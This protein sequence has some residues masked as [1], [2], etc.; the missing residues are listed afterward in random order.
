M[1]ACWVAA[2]RSSRLK[3]GMTANV[4]AAIFGGM[5][6]V[7]PPLGAARAA[8]TAWVGDEHAA[9]RLVTAVEATGSGRR[10]DAGLEI[11]MAPGWHTYWRTP[12]DAGIPPE[13]DWTGSTNLAR[14]EIAW[15]APTRLS[16]HGLES[17]V[18]PDHALA[19]ITI[20]LARP[21]ESLSLRASVDYAA[22]AEVCIPYH[23]DLSLALPAGVATPGVEAPLI[24]T[25]R[26]RVPGGLDQAGMALV[27]ATVAPAREGDAVVDVRL[28]STGAPL[29]QPDLFIEGPDHGTI[30]RPEITLGETGRS[31]ELRV[32]VTGVSAAVLAAEPLIFTLTDGLNRAAE[33]T[34][35]PVLQAGSVAAPS[36]L[37]ILG[38]ALLGGL[39]LNLMPCVLPVLS[40]K[41]LA[42]ARLS[43]V[44]RRLLRLSLVITA[45]GV[46]AHLRRSPRR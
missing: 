18:Y 2:K 24:G 15:P 39:I 45:G 4:I 11:R 35:T 27:A 6:L 14:A 19:P 5:A 46:L 43:G 26:A 23:A 36:N 10:I 16:E 38:I 44:D 28:R 9:A 42:V 12:G 3:A 1:A 21:G 37:A 41:L 13:I 8:A 25:A 17:Y 7:A 33:F 30:A 20:E 29:R 40:L 32:Q 34:A 22:C 31:V